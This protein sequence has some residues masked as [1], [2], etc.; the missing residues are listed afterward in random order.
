MGSTEFE[1]AAGGRPAAR[2]TVGM[3]YWRVQR[4]ARY[5]DVSRK[6]VYQLVA[7]R[8]LEAVRLGPRQMRIA[9]DSLEAYLERLRAQAR[10]EAGF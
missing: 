6:R 5:L 9:R 7:E 2:R 3:E 10:E 8:R 1:S 4:V